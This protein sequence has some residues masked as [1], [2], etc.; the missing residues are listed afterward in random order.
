[1]EEYTTSQQI[2]NFLLL[3]GG[4]FVVF[5]VLIYGVLWLGM[6][7]LGGLVKQDDEDPSFLDGN[8]RH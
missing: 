6:A 3:M 8:S 7:I 5:N 4:G 1:M 2:I